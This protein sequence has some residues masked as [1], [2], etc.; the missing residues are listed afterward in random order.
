MNSLKRTCEFILGVLIAVFLIAR[1]SDGQVS[2]SLVDYVMPYQPFK[3]I[4][5]VVLI[6]TASRLIA[7]KPKN[8]SRFFYNA[9]IRILGDHNPTRVR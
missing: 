5:V 8:Y 1:Y 6:L 2:R 9:L 4:L 3:A 7:G